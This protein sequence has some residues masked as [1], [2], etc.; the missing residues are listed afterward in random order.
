MKN[1]REKLEE[2]LA[3]R[4]MLLSGIN[5]CEGVDEV[6]TIEAKED[7]FAGGENLTNPIDQVKI[8]A[9]ESN[10]AAPESADPQTGEVTTS[11]T[12]SESDI[13]RII[14]KVQS[15]LRTRVNS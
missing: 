6:D 10:V 3:N 1:K 11:D 14:T 2:A 9:D 15:I 13:S 4:Y 5:L 7:A 12:I 8:V